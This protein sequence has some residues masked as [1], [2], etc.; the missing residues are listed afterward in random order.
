MEHHNK[1]AILKHIIILSIGVGGPCISR[2]ARGCG[3]GRCKES[4]KLGM[5]MLQITFVYILKRYSKNSSHLG[6]NNLCILLDVL[7]T[8]DEFSEY[9]IYEFLEYLIVLVC[10]HLC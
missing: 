8:I 9:N 5:L 3:S 7:L 2:Q 10:V 1:I 4:S 6:C